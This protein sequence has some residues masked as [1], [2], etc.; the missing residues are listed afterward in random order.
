MIIG[1]LFLSL[2]ILEM[3]TNNGVIRR[4][5]TC[6]IYKNNISINNLIK[7]DIFCFENIKYSHAHTLCNTN[8]RSE[9]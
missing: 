6:I 1:V 2:L 8:C 4:V 9:I 7:S 5:P 3:I